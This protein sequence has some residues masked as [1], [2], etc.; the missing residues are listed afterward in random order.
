MPIVGSWS[1]YAVTAAFAY[2]IPAATPNAAPTDYYAALFIDDAY[3]GAGTEVSVA[4]YTRQAITLTL[5]SALHYSNDAD[6]IWPPL[7]GVLAAGVALFDDPTAG[8][9]WAWWDFTN[10]FNVAGGLRLA[11]GNLVLS[12][13][14]RP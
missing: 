14:D 7:A 8:N 10:P 13:G 2:V 1:D 3:P 5:A 9:S 12:I 11:T 4:D 6:I